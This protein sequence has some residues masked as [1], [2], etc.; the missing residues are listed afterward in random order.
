MI[1]T[2]LGER[3]IAAAQKIFN[4]AIWVIGITGILIAITGNVF[5]R[6]LSKLLGATPDILDK[7]MAYLWYIVT[8]APFQLFSFLLG[9]MVRNDGR[10]KLAMIAMILGAA[11]NIV[12]DYAFMYPLNMGI[13][14]AALATALGPI[15]SV[16]ILL[17]HFILKKGN[18]YF[19]CCSLQLKDIKQILFYGFPSF[20]MEF[21][22]GMITFI[23]NFAI[24]YFGYG[25]I[26]LAAYLV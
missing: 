4:T 23:Y 9:S 8:F 25:E 5:L 11:S 22:I 2:R 6:P 12:L 21:T 20:I 10:P 13:A 26:G 1:A 7:A 3:K 16:L 15:F 17:P 14:G 24:S 19:M 18:F